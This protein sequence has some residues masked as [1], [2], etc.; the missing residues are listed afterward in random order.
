MRGIGLTLSRLPAAGAILAGAA[1]LAGAVSTKAL[2]QSDDTAMAIPRL[3]PHGADGIALPQP[4][5]AEQAAGLRRIFA[6]QAH[7]RMTMALREAAALQPVSPLNQRMLGH[8][9]ADRYL[10]RF[11][12]AKVDELSEWINRYSDLPDVAAV[13]AL[14]RERLPRS[15]AQAA[16]P[17]PVTLLP[18]RLPDPIPEEAEAPGQAIARNPMLDVTLRERAQAGNVRGALSLL[19]HTKGLSALYGAQLRAE[20]AQALFGQ[21]RDAEA[22]DMASAAA[23]QARGQVGLADYVAGLAAWRLDRAALAVEHFE[24]A[25][26]AEV[27]PAA[28]HAAASFWAA[29][30]HLRAH[31]P[32]GYL[33]WMKRATS[34]P[35]TFYGLLARRVL[36]TGIGNGF[37]WDQETLGEADIEAVAATPEGL[38]AFA[39]LQIGENARA[40]GEL[41]RLAARSRDDLPL[42]RAVMLVAD[43]AGLYD[44]SA[45]LAALVQSED[46]R[47]RDYARYPVPRLLP[48]EGFHIDPAMLYALTRV[49]SNFDTDAISPVGARGLLQIMPVTAGYMEGD[50]ELAGSLGDRLHNPAFNLAIG[51]RYIRYLAQ[52][53]VVQGDLIRLLAS[54]NGGPGNCARWVADIHDDGDPLLFIEAIPNDET[55][56]FVQRVLASTWI[57]A[58]RLRLPAPSLDELASGVFPRYRPLEDA[59]AVRVH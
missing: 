57:Y 49:E 26:R 31:D 48:R 45:Q 9:L 28:L 27:A 29:R 13:T 17:A 36:G 20:L 16:V 18:D 54:Y 55:R 38:A 21:N 50:P 37:S 2:A 25:S 59:V 3:A 32:A 46:G 15:S 34:E 56:S 10:S 58:M 47:P 8:V 51:Q 24:A 40:D 6:D 12:R 14:L 41:R 5:P 33:P 22:L 42:S 23:R 19:A 44:L 4:L 53:D 52:H 35:R 11:Y 30:A 43:K 39:L 7:G 1:L